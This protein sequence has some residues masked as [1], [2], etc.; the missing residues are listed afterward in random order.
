MKEIRKEEIVKV[1]LYAFD[2]LAPILILCFVG[3]FLKVRAVFN[4]DF[5]KKINRFAF[6]YC[7]PALMFA[8]LY[9]LEG[10]KN[11][12]VKLGGYLLCSLFVITA[13]AFVLG[14]L[15]T[16]QR[17]RKGVLMQAGYRSNFALIGMALVEGLV[18]S[19]GLGVTASMQAPVVLYFNFFSVLVFCIYAEDAKFSL[20]K[21]GH[22]IV[23]NPLLQGLS[24]GLVALIIREFIP[25]DVDGNL[26][27][28]LS[29]DLPWLYTTIQYFSRL[30]TPMA[31]ISLGGQFSFS[32]V[33]D[34][35][36][37]V[38]GGVLMRLILAPILGFT[39]TF[40]AVRAGIFEMT[41]AVTAL[42]IAAY[43]SPL[44]VSTAPMAAEMHADATL[45]GQLVVWTSTFS[46][47][48]IFILVVIFR[49]LGFL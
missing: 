33:G 34:M 4:E 14:N 40:M 36:K 38:V 16:D 19:S 8:N 21:V 10:L 7:F 22:S 26:A 49:A 39:M 42:L 29:R 48:T 13:I 12:N 25:V 44:A 5:F 20:R 23:T 17:P 15:L 45:A 37:E 27:F 11:I 47:F 30:A 9:G 18:G 32:K 6:H 2:A 24:A 3:Y 41:P 35:K 31:L 46:M 1:F 28:S 43:G